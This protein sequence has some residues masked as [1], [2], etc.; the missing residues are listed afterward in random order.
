M[1][2]RGLVKKLTARTYNPTGGDGPFECV[3]IVLDH[4]RS[5]TIRRES[6][7]RKDRRCNLDFAIGGASRGQGGFAGSGPVFGFR[8]GGTDRCGGLRGV[9]PGFRFSQGRYG[10]V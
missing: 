5:I 10:S 4:G 7:E 1:G 3:E 8:E 2:S 9:R 6:R